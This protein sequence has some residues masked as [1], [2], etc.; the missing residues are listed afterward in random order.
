MHKIEFNIGETILCKENYVY[1]SDSRLLKDD[2]K[3]VS[4][5]KNKNYKISDFS[6]WDD[7]NK[8][9]MYQINNWSFV[10]TNEIHNLF[11]PKFEDYFYTKKEIRKMKLNKIN[12]ER[13]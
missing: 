4:F 5:L 8:I 1:V 3:K 12:N 6:Y 2:P 13:D 9:I 7:E 11:V 10:S